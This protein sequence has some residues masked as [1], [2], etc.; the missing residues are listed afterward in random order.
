MNHPGFRKSF[1]AG[2]K[3]Q[4]GV[5]GQEVI[6]G[7]CV[8]ACVGVCVH[9][10]MHVQTCKSYD[11]TEFGLPMLSRQLCYPW[12]LVFG[13]IPQPRYEFQVTKM[14]EHLNEQTGTS[15]KLYN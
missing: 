8:S 9:A 13:A 10:C 12:Y 4:H 2:S 5:Q 15:G 3:E 14:C 11:Y 7:M 6:A 1:Q